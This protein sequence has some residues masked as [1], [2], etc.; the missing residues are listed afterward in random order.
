MKRLHHIILL[1]VL[2]AACTPKNS[3]VSTFTIT[4]SDVLSTKAKVTIESSN[5]DAYYSYG[6]IREDMDPYFT[7]SDMENAKFQIDFCKERIDLADLDEDHPVSYTD[8]YCYRGKQELK[9]TYLIP[10][11]DNKVIVFQVD[12]KTL[13]V[14]G[15]PVSTVFHTNIHL[16]K[17]GR[18]HV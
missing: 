3:R 12:P 13:D 15:E 14:V 17:I 18:A 8:L 7:M 6:F 16:Q 1:A 10:D 5:P 2:A 11:Q 9:Y 4:V